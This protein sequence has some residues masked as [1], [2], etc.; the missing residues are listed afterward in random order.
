MIYFNDRGLSASRHSDQQSWLL[1]AGTS[2]TEFFT[3]FLHAF[4]RGQTTAAF[5][6]ERKFGPRIVFHS[7]SVLDNQV[8]SIQ[9]VG[10]TLQPH[11]RVDA[12]G[13][14]GE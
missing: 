12:A 6:Y 7:F 1:F 11:W 9:S 2:A 13:G 8:T 3:P 10:I 14:V 4:Q 5:F